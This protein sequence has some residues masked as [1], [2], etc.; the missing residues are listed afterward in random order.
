MEL[1]E[2]VDL[3]R[4]A[5]SC[6]YFTGAD[7]QALMYSA[8]LEA[9]HS[10]IDEDKQGKLSIF[11]FLTRSLLLTSFFFITKQKKEKER[12]KKRKKKKKGENILYLQLKLFNLKAKQ[13]SPIQIARRIKSYNRYFFLYSL[14]TSMLIFLFTG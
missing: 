5:E 14:F 2:D 6:D 7:L 4:V 1:A 3:L 9:I 8:Q 12:K 10:L 13:K 11:N